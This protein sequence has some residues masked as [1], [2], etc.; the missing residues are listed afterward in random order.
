MHLDCLV[1]FQ[2]KTELSSLSPLSLQISGHQISF[3]FCH[4][5]LMRRVVVQFLPSSLSILTLSLSELVPPF[6][7]HSCGLYV[8]FTALQLVQSEHVLRAYPLNLQLIPG[9]LQTKWLFLFRESWRQFISLNGFAL[10]A[11]DRFNCDQCFR[12]ALRLV[13][14]LEEQMKRSR[15]ESQKEHF[16]MDNVSQSLSPVLSKDWAAF[17]PWV[18]WNSLL[19]NNPSL[20][21]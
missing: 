13:N 5:L 3:N 2:L 1:R 17:P 21:R 20:L 8:D 12:I 9:L 4:L 14:H 6:R 11:H 16:W 10:Q 15:M 19:V 7:T 18:L